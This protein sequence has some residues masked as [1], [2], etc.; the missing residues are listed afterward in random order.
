MKKILTLVTT[1]ALLCSLSVGSVSAFNDLDA[2]QKESIMALKQQGVVSGVDDQH[3]V[4]Q[5]KISYAQSIQLLVKGMGL[6]IDN[7]QFIKEPLASDFFTNVPNDAWYAEAFIIAQ[8]NGLPIPKDVDPNA[9]ITREQFADLLIHAV[10]TKGSFPV[11]KMLVIF[12]DADEIDPQLNY[13]LQRMILHKITELD[14]DQKFHPKKEMTRGQAAVWVHSAM[15]F[16]ESHSE[17]PPVQEEVQVLVEKVNDQVNKITLSRG[18]KPSGGYD[19]EIN[20]IR[21]EN[22]G[23]A[24]ISYTLVDPKPDSSNT[25]AITEPKAET[26]VS[27]KYTVTAEPANGF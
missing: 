26:Y 6:N 19:I 5:G 7:I 15:K 9:T 24:V 13:S 16:V 27:S 17:K 22:D 12:E 4:P 11:I 21:F 18:Q 10:D 20:S 14:K 2:S 23:R 25:S 8:L 1:T 3:F